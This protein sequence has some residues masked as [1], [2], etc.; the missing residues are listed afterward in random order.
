MLCSAPSHVQAEV[1]RDGCV[2]E[3]DPRSVTGLFD[4]N[5]QAARLGLYFF[6]GQLTILDSAR[7]IDLQA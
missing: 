4:A 1:G 6:H 7:A 3:Q 5:D 2:I